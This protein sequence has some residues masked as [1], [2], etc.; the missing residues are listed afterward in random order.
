MTVLDLGSGAGIDV[1]VASRHVGSTG[2]VI[3][4]DMTREM[5]D[6][7]NANK[8]KLKSNNVEF[9]LG[10]IEHLPVESS[11]VDRILSNCVIN[12]VPDKRAAFA[13]MFR[14]LRPGGKFTVSDVVSVGQIPEAVRNDLLEWAGCVAGAL[15]KDEY[16][17]TVREAGFADLQLSAEKPYH[18]DKNLSFGLRSI[19]LSAT[20]P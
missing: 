4:V 11:S 10:E 9:R 15:E 12:L 16:L 8:E 18:L 17:A 5:I 3:G 6:R 14:V 1:F 20:K 13:E 2:M 7:A 19:T